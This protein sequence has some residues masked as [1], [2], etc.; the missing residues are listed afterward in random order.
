MESPTQP[1]PP[2]PTQSALPAWLGPAICAAIVAVFYAVVGRFG[3]GGNRSALSWLESTW[4]KETRY[5]HGYMV[6]VI[7]IGLIA[8]QWKNLVRLAKQ[9]QSNWLGLPVVV[10]GIVFFLIGYRCGQARF[11]VAGLPMILWG[12]AL[13]LWG[14]QMSRLVLFPL[15]LL[16]LA[17]PMSEFQQATVK[18]QII[19]SH[20]AQWCSGLFGVQTVVKGVQMFSV[21]ERWL[22]LE[23]DEGCGG[24]RSL[25]ALIMISTVWA[26]LAKVSLWKKGVLLLSAFPLAIFGNMLRL[27]SIFVIAEYGNPEFARNTW[28]D[29]SGLLIFYPISLCLLLLVHS[30]LE[31]GLPW[32][33]PKKKAVR[34]VVTR[35][36][37]ASDDNTSDRNDKLSV[38]SAPTVP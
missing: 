15:F 20:L 23:I 32:S 11:S 14:W 4:N 33:G 24:I 13:Y 19:S 29:W 25:M 18:L 5:E 38:S 36:T 10:L 7:M 21:S 37:G 6:P 26:Y 28:H 35:Q 27:T 17:V 9:G 31:Q 30:A 16:W 22:P 34:R 3:N 2:E 8:W 12:S 1:S